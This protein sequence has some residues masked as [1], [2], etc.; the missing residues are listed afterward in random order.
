M[1]EEERQRHRAT[2]PIEVLRV[3]MVDETLVAMSPTVRLYWWIGNE[4]LHEQQFTLLGDGQPADWDIGAAWDGVL[5]DLRARR[6]PAQEHVVR[7]AQLAK[8]AA[9]VGAKLIEGQG[10]HEVELVEHAGKTYDVTADDFDE[11]EAEVHGVLSQL[12][13]RR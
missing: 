7:Y 4:L 13:G 11:M 5:E 6:W 3:T 1:T 2:A 8:R 12:Q 9:L 10:T